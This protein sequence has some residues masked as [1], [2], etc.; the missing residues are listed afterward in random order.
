MAMLDG[1]KVIELGQNLAGPY[2][3]QILGDLGA[4]VIK[5]EKPG[6]DDARGWGPPFASDGVAIAFHTI[7]R[8]KRSVVMD[9]SRPEDLAALEALV[10]E[11]DIFVHNM[12]PGAPVKIGIGP[13]RLRALNP[14]LIYCD[15][16]AFGHKGPLE[17]K[18]GYE[19][20]LQ[21]F[22]GL[23]SVNG[24]P[25]GPPARMGASVIDFGTG[26]WTALGALAAL[27][28]RHRTGQG[29]VVNT[30]LFETALGWVGS[31]IATYAATGKLPERQST[32][33]ASLTPYQAFQTANGPLVITAGNDRLFA[34]LASVL[35]HPEWADDARYRT[36][37]DRMAHRPQVI[38]M[39]QAVIATDTKEAWADRLE[40][41]GVPCAPIN[42]I[43]ELHDHAQT[44]AIGV[45]QHDAQSGVTSWVAPL[46]FDGKRAAYGTPAPK[47]G[48]DTEA[49]LKRAKAAE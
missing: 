15:I 36:N 34:K 30:S 47:L 26:M 48:A 40:A 12:R 28:Q 8:G 39:V 43:A 14:R 18:P 6:G 32:G 17:G 16:S 25:S 11:A 31:H 27:Q 33:H 5:I 4:D 19:P 7:N 23:V 35:G 46:S 9:L 45:I 24:D 49:V 21:A 3:S 29:C 20:L 1:I 44:A 37:A 13:A 38:A 10:M 2:A 41:V 22:G 42:D